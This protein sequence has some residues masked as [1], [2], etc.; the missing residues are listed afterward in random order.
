M[1][2]IKLATHP[3]VL[4]SFGGA[5]LVSYYQGRLVTQLRITVKRVYKALGALDQI[6]HHGDVTQTHSHLRTN[7]KMRNSEENPAIWIYITL[8]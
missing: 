5:I 2:L 3:Y 4:S 1:I 8:F 7:Y 6:T